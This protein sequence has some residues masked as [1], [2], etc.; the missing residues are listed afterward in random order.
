MKNVVCLLIA[1]LMALAGLGLP[2]DSSFAADSAAPKVSSDYVQAYYFHATRRCATCMKLEQYSRAAIEANF[3]E[4][5]NNKTLRFA[6]VNFDEPENRHFLQDY[7]LIYRSVVL[8][9]F[10]DGKQVTYKNLER[11]WELVGSEKDFSEYVKTEVEAML[12]EL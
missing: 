5:L 1:L 6:E 10:K 7:N 11:I 2:G 9:R 8:V 4:Q 3:K 12:K